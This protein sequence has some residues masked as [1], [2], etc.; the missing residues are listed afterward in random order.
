[1]ADTYEIVFQPSGRRGT[2]AEGT[3]LLAA[4]QELGVGIEALCGGKGV[5]GKCRVIIEEGHFEKLGVF[6][7]FA[8]ASDLTETEKKL[9]SEKELSRGYR[10][11]CLAQLKGDLV[12]TI[13]EESRSAKQIILEAGKKRTFSLNPAV[14]QYQLQLPPATLQDA[15]DD[16]SRIL[17]TLAQQYHLKDIAIDYFVLREIPRIIR[18]DNWKI[19][20]T[21]WNNRE[22]IRIAAGWNTPHSIG[23]AIDIGTT[24]LAA[25]L[26]D[27]N[28]G[29]LLGKSS[30]MNPEISYGE[31]VLAR[32]SYAM[33]EEDGRRRLQ[34][35][36]QDAINKLAA[37]MTARA[38]KT[39]DDVE[40]MVLVYNTAMHHFTLGLDTRYIGRSP[41]V[42]TASDA[43]DIKA[44]DLGIHINPSGNIHSLPI[45]A[46]FVG[47]DNVAVLL[48]EEPYASDSIKLIIDIGTNGEINLGNKNRLL[49]SSCATGPALEGAQISFGMRAAPGSIEAV[50]INPETKEP[51]YKVIGNNIWYPE[52][53]KP[54]A[55]GIC[56]SG[57]I[58][59]VA[60]LYT[61]GI[62]SSNGR[63]NKNVS[64]PRVRKDT[65]GRMEYVLAWAEETSVNKDIT[66]SQSD[67][68]AVQLAKGALYVGAKYLMEKYGI[69]Q[70][71]EV[72]L[73]GAFGSYINKQS[74]ME[75]GMFPDCDLTHVYAVGNA[76]GDGARIALLN[77]DKRKEAVQIARKV[78]FVETAIEPDFQ[79]RFMDALAIP[80][81]KD[82]FPHL[83]KNNDS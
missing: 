17:D 39:V 22:I 74:A 64:T 58:D 50:S 72:I 68:R 13:P 34:Q 78:E 55:Q 27:L 1:M 18:E 30:C 23:I 79:S 4:A 21:V 81:A 3:T 44:R 63:I 38:G 41:F 48:A 46:G 36:M 15:R 10:L 24:T 52:N 56:G 53:K 29:E 19:T 62:I 75:L 32:I 5:C 70:V 42:P 6:S 37:E 69:T 20:V 61:A 76:A 8:H 25:F 80:H 60:A 59:A 45:E 54:G 16:R 7:S 49:S 77:V 11:A 51:R 82:A 2:I 14:R 66:I 28:T 65:R 43:L 73:A 35:V 67:I 83:H 9:F 33:S 40:E 26:C 12:I 71:D 47:A 57:I 31:D